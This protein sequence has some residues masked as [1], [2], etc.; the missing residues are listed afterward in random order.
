[1][2]VMAVVTG[3]AFSAS[4]VAHAL[5]P[6]TTRTISGKVYEGEHL[7][8]ADSSPLLY[9]LAV[10]FEKGPLVDRMQVVDIDRSGK[11][12]LTQTVDFDGPSPKAYAFS[13]PVAK[14]AGKLTVTPTELVMEMT[15]AG[16][17]KVSREARPPL[18]A[19]GPSIT[20]L[21]E[22]HVH[23][24]SAGRTVVFRMVVVNRLETYGFRAV[25]EPMS[26][27][28]PIAQVKA[29]SG[30]A[31][32]WSLTAGSLGCLPRRLS[33]S[34]TRRRGKPSRSAGRSRRRM[35]R[36][37][38]SRAAPSG[39]RDSDD[40]HMDSFPPRARSPWDRGHVRH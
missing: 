1:M 4:D 35:A 32:E 8:L 9:T 33:P 34:S 24:L 26:A 15:E 6:P 17:T 3:V 40:L 13:N 20:R 14:Q 5:D 31:C 23:D 28:E 16:K 19:V 27:N 22:Q 36:E 30:Y 12:F 2:S 7:A 10:T 25:R 21:V 29:G 18:F 39:T 11:T 38:S 37:G